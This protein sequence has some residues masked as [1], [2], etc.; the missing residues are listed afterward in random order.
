MS[1]ISLITP[2]LKRL[3]EHEA[4]AIV[5]FRFAEAELLSGI[6]SLLDWRLLG[7]LSRLIIDGF[8][9]GERDETLLMP[10]GRRLPQ[11]CLLVLGLGQRDRFDQ[12]VFESQIDRMFSVLDGLRAETLVLALPGRPEGDCSTAQAIEWFLPCYDRRGGERTLTIVEPVGAQK[13]MLPYIERWRLKA[14]A[15]S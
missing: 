10:L 15:L 9:Q 7:H 12:Q 2:E 8:F 14:V 5:L 6:T 11:D 3:D 4:D 13:V 1:A